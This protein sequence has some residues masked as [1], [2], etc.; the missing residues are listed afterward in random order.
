MDE[1]KRILVPLDGSPLAERALPLA[2]SLAQKFDSEII[3]LRIL[4]VSTLTLPTWH[5]EAPPDWIVEAHEHIHEEV[6]NYLKTQQDQLRQQGFEVRTLLRGAS[7]AEGILE[8]AETQEVDL[9]VMSTHGR[10]GL[11]RWALGSVAD[12][13]M[14]HS[15][16]PVL[17]IRQ[18]E[19]NHNK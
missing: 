19:E 18:T 13:V 11:T 15:H 1:F 14:G 3:L 6:K 8:I 7:P 9:I 5:M 10:S 16:C 17:L 4:D 2:T 12:K